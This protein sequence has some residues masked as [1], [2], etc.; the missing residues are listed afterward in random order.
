M[1]DANLIE[2]NTISD[3]PK[4]IGIQ[5]GDGN[6]I[7]NNTI[8]GTG[9]GVAVIA[10]SY[11]DSVTAWPCNF[12]FFMPLPGDTTNPDYLYYYPHDCHSRNNQILGNTISGFSRAW[13]MSPVSDDSNVFLDNIVAYLNHLSFLP[14][15]LKA[16]ME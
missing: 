14:V 8:T 12:S 9:S 1:S 6:I 13:E 16:T 2:N 7:R 5:G 3:V 10:H 15:D 11:S 4:G